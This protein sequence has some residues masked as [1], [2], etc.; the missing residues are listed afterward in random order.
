MAG[1][2]SR[3]NGAIAEVICNAVRSGVWMDTAAR[4]AG[5][6]PRT[7][8]KWL[9]KGNAY[10]LAQSR[11]EN[12]VKGGLVKK[13]SLYGKFVKKVQKAMAEGEMKDLLKIDIAS[14]KIWQAAAWKLE[15][16]WPQRWAL[17]KRQETRTEIHKT[18]TN[19]TI[20][21]L[22]LPLEV[23]RQVLEAMLRQDQANEKPLAA[24]VDK[25]DDVVDKDLMPPTDNP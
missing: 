18:E 1:R 9:E 12:L 4:I 8:Y 16:R 20:E 22:D 24:I 21:S 11:G 2:T 6:N 10:L 7:L 15:R 25:R 23:K 14:E 17:L 5:I 13:Y 19:I 3:L